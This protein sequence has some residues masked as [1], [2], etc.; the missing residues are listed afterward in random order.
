MACSRGQGV[1]YCDSDGQKRGV[2][3]QGPITALG[4]GRQTHGGRLS[5]RRSIRSGRPVLKPNAV[6]KDDGSTSMVGLTDLKLR[7][8]RWTILS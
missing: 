2:A 8:H 4:D 1:N 3:G 6:V 5:W 7:G